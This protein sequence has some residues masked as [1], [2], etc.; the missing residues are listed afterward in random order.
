[1][2]SR[3]LCQILLHY[4]ILKKSTAEGYRILVE[5]YGYYALSE[6]T[7][8]DWLRRFKNNHFD[9]KDKER[10]GAPKKFKDK[11]SEALLNE[12]SRQTLA[13]LVKSLGVDHT[14]V[15]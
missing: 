3:I 9:V 7:Y 13:E 12:N 8:R 4:Y 15:S 14:T 11:E 6:T 2:L 10:S 1:M 5:T